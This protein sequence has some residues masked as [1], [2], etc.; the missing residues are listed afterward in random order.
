MIPQR[1]RPELKPSSTDLVRDPQTEKDGE[2][3]HAE[4]AEPWHGSTSSAKRREH[5]AETLIGPCA[6]SGGEYTHQE[7]AIHA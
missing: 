7:S 1:T 3:R 5:A 2:R 4:L 6:H